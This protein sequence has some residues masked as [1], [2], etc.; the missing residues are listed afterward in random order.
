V[1]DHPEF[2]MNSKPHVAS[3][4]DQLT[5]VRIMEALRKVKLI[6]KMKL[7]T[8]INCKVIY[9]KWWLFF[10]DLNPETERMQNHSSVNS[11]I[12]SE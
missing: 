7:T 9:W 3:Y 11:S 6:C 4:S 12:I 5:R 2:H 1:W 10:I 8:H